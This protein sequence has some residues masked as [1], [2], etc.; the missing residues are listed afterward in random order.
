MQEVDVSDVSQFGALLMHRCASL[1][2]HGWP[3]QVLVRAQPDGTHALVRDGCGRVLA[4]LFGE[5][6]RPIRGDNG[7]MLVQVVPS[8]VS[9]AAERWEADKRQE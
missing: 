3:Y 8:D 7:G 5:D 6:Q 2:Q 1:D 4:F 9:D